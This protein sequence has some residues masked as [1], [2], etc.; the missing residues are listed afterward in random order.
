MN[1]WAG[2]VLP[3]LPSAENQLLKVLL[4]LPGVKGAYGIKGKLIEQSLELETKLARAPQPH[5][6][7]YLSGAHLG[8]AAPGAALVLSEVAPTQRPV[9]C[10]ARSPLAGASR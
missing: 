1:C 7:L 8:S 3:T 10:A 9:T 5:H 6:W 4:L 2:Q